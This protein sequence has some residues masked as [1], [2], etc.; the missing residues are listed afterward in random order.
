MLDTILSA[1][2]FILASSSNEDI[3]GGLVVL[4]LAWTPGFIFYSI[5]Y[6][7]YRNQDKRHNYEFETKIAVRNATSQDEKYDT[8]RRTKN[9]TVPG[10]NNLDTNR[11]T[12]AEN[13]TIVTASGVDIA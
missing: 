9:K 7:K 3:G 6:R 11:K 2:D 10:K 4:V 13:G 1:S 12:P 8:V 5:I